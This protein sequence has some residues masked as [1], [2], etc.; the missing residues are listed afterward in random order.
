MVCGL[1]F[2]LSVDVDDVLHRELHLSM[3]RETILR[4]QIKLHR[5]FQRVL[6]LDVRICDE[7]LLATSCTTM[8]YDSYWVGLYGN[9][10]VQYSD[11]R[12]PDSLRHNLQIRLEGQKDE[13][14][15]GQDASYKT[16]IS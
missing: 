16:T 2:L 12:D 13:G 6:Y 5:A 10:G 11:Q 14:L 3:H 9:F 1:S 8:V 4:Q 7:H 15:E